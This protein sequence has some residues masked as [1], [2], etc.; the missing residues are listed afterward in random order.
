MKFLTIVFAAVLALSVTPMFAQEETKDR[1]DKAMQPAQTK[2]PEDQPKAAT[3]PSAAAS[4]PGSASTTTSESTTTTSASSAG[5]PDAEMMKQMMEMAKLNE[6]HKM[7]AELNGT[8]S[9][10][11]KFWPAPG[12]PPQES[13]GTATRKSM[14]DGRF[15]VMDVNGPMQMP[16]PA[17]GKMKT[18]D[19]KGHGIEGYDNVRK[20][21][22][23][24]WVD[25]MGTGIMMSEG[26]FDPSTK[27]FTYTSEYEAIP[28]MKQQ[29]REVLTISDKNHMNFEWFENRGGQEMKTMEIAYTRK[30]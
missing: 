6:N 21:F 5:A 27:T 7:L 26:T 16:D 28:G 20:K 8:W 15:F 17:T 18:L 30:K 12:V 1:T 3:S 2:L 4:S 9:Y 23:G 10:T 25:N 13:K 19:F 11:I 24:T 29:I 14:F 22:V